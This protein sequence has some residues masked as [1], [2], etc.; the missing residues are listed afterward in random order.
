MAL[1]VL[2]SAEWR[3]GIYCSL[4]TLSCAT[5]VCLVLLQSQLDL[6][7]CAVISL[8]VL[9]GL[10]GIQAQV[11]AHFRR[12]AMRANWQLEAIAQDDF[13]QT[14]KPHY[15]S[16]AVAEF[17]QRLVA[18]SVQLHS[19][20]RRYHSQQ[21][22][23][24]QLI[25][26]LNSPI[27]MFDDNLKLAY[28]NGAFELLYHRPWQE[29]K[30]MSSTQFGLIQ[31]DKQWQFD[32]A[33]QQSRWQLQSSEFFQEGKQFYLL[34]ALDI[35]K[36]LRK[37]ELAAWQHLIRVIS[38]EIHNSLTPISSLAQTLLAK[39]QGQKEQQ[40]L[41]VIGQRCQHL[42]QFVGQYAKVTRT[43]TLAREPVSVLLLLTSVAALFDSTDIKVDCTVKGL[44]LDKALIEQVL[45][46]LVKNAIEANTDTAKLVLKA[47]YQQQQAVIEVLD[48]GP[49]FANLDNI[50]TP[51]YSTKSAGQGIGL[52]FSR[53]IVELHDGQ[54]LCENTEIG[55]RVKMIFSI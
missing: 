49:G 30:G 38:H 4:L 5:L 53:N 8:S 41:S 43:P 36:A 1:K 25:D 42:R 12:I 28:A 18:L 52:T 29:C 51:F 10:G 14:I 33:S 44:E 47:Y 46:N 19:Q 20:K 23:I 35:T 24:Y 37:K 32:S 27:L 15:T 48:N 26:S 21:F 31:R 39:A 13:T 50:L 34:V 16:G 22:I 55:G 40:A 2:A 9:V 3:L 17:E 6:V 45:I 7:W 54:L 11:L